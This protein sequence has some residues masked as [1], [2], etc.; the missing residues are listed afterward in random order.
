MNRKCVNK[1]CCVF[2]EPKTYNHLYCSPKCKDEVAKNKPTKKGKKHALQEIEQ[3]KKLVAK[4]LEAV[5]EVKPK[6][7][8]F[9]LIRSNPVKRLCGCCAKT[10]ETKEATLYCGELDNKNS[11]RAKMAKIYAQPRERND[12]VS[13]WLN[14]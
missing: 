4:E 3:S 14:Q 10:F 6:I 5:E 1:T 8:P 11:C 12:T 2:F 13:D 7:K 9:V